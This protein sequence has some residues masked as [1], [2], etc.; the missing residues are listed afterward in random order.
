MKF[1][2]FQEVWWLLNIVNDFELIGIIEWYLKIINISKLFDLVFIISIV[3]FGPENQDVQKL[4]RVMSTTQSW[5]SWVFEIKR[6]IKEKKKLV[7][8]LEF[9]LSRNTGTN[10]Y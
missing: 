4:Q 9:L 8:H 7:E 3:I 10:E 2:Y 5:K 1:F 6:F